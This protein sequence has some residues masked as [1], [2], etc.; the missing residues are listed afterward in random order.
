MTKTENLLLSELDYTPKPPSFKAV[1]ETIC[2]YKNIG[3]YYVI[4]KLPVI[5][6]KNLGI[7]TPLETFA[8][9][10][11]LRLPQYFILNVDETMYLV[12]TSGCSYCRYV[13]LL[14]Y[15]GINY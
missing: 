5:T 10:K 8:L 7:K 6:A 14:E 3:I 13:A 15:K 12:N 1:K 9:A 2:F 11:Y 4:E